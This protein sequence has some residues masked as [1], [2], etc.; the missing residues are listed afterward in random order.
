MVELCNM[1]YFP[2]KVLH[3]LYVVCFQEVLQCIKLDFHLVYLKK[4]GHVKNCGA[5]S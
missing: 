4:S 1:R 3:L 5:K 2:E